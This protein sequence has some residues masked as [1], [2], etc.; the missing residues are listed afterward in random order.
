MTRLP[1]A[2]LSRQSRQV[3]LLRLLL[4]VLALGVL[5][6]TVEARQV[7]LAPDSVVWSRWL[8]LA[9]GICSGLLSILIR[10]TVHQWQLVLHLVFDLAWIGLLL[11]LTGGVASP[12]LPLLFAVVL[13]ANLVLPG[14]LPFVMPALAAL[15]L[16]VT[17]A[18]Y[19]AHATPFPPALLEAYPGL[20]DT[21]R[22]LGYLAV[23]VGAL[24]IVDLLAQLL[25]RRL[26]EQRLFTDELLDQLGEGVIAIDQ[27]GVIAYI[28]DEARRLLALPQAQRGQLA[29]LALQDKNLAMVRELIEEPRLPQLTRLHGINGRHL[30]LRIT[31]LF[32]RSQRPLGRT[33]LIADE[34]RLRLLE[35]SSNRSE[36]LASLGEMAAGIAHEIR[37]PL[38]SLRGCAQELA[39]ICSKADHADAVALAGILVGESDRLAR[40]VSDFLALSRLRETRHEPVDLE[41]LLI[42]AERMIRLRSDLPAGLELRVDLAEDTPSVLGDADQLKQILLNLLANSLDAVRDVAAPF[43]HC[44]A[45]R[46]ADDNPLGMP[47]VLLQVIDRGCGIP[48]ELQARVFTPFFSTKAQGTGLGLSLVNRIVREHEGLLALTSAPGTGTTITIHLPAHSQT[49]TFRRALGNND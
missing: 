10:W 28:N 25:T 11:H 7:E 16:A 36:H 20:I 35:E 33:L 24:F 39:E 44:H 13:V 42:E 34:T 21:H 43:V 29:Q 5:V 26:R 23:Q 1:P 27:D 12:A 15:V 40:I 18:L 37:N 31:H 19:L 6:F 46:A 45:E 17:A 14:V 22:I 41:P 8:L 9:V 47:A 30:V 48:H 32:D 38:T 4:V 49:R 3:S 2:P